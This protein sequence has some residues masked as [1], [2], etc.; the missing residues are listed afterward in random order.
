M[1]VTEVMKEAHAWLV[2]SF[3]QIMCSE[4]SG[5]PGPKL[6]GFLRGDQLGNGVGG[7]R[8]HLCLAKSSGESTQP[9]AG[10]SLT[11]AQHHCHPVGPQ[12][13]PPATLSLPLNLT[14]LLLL[15]LQ[16]VLESAWG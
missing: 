13:S 4:L 7:G 10:A 15:T 1:D 8:S 14:A 5:Q 6:S 3:P 9:P 16:A 2:T 11:H 12:P